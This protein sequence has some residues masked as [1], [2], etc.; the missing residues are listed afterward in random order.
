[1]VC[2]FSV[3]RFISDLSVKQQELLLGGQNVVLQSNRPVTP[4]RNAKEIG[5]ETKFSNISLQGVTNASPTGSVGNSVGQGRGS[6]TGAQD[7]LVLPPFIGI[8]ETS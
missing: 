5:S 7:S 8:S 6:D 4:L 1:M 3:I 2:H